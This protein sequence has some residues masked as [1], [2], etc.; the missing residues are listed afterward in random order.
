MSNTKASTSTCVQQIFTLPTQ[1]TAFK[2]PPSHYGGLASDPRGW[3]QGKLGYRPA[4]Q[5]FKPGLHLRLPCLRQETQSLTLDP[6]SF[7]FAYKIDLF[8]KGN[9]WNYALKICWYHICRLLIANFHTLWKGFIPKRHP[10]QDTKYWNSVYP[11]KTGD[12][13]NHTLFSSTYL[14]SPNKGVPPSPLAFDWFV[15]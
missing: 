15:S 14:F 11:V 3:M 10:V 5:A 12:P 7:P 6:D 8:F 4:T 1:H 13:K 9:S 2:Y